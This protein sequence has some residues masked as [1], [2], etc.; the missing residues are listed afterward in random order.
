MSAS[1]GPQAGVTVVVAVPVSFDEFGSPEPTEVVAE[2]V[3]DPGDAG[4]AAV[5]EIAGAS[6]G[7]RSARL[8]V[9][10][11]DPPHVQPS[12]DAPPSATPA[13]SV[14]ATATSDAVVGPALC[15]VSVYASAS[16][17]HA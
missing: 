13:G 2:I 1:T 14:M 16:P 11:G 3:T 5:R 17:A 6:P 10:I 15:A 12:P 8:Q 7:S 9:T 4:A